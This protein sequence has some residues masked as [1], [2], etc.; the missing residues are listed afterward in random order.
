MILKKFQMIFFK[1]G[2]FSFEN[3]KISLEDIHIDP[4][5]LI[6]MCEIKTS[7]VKRLRIE[8]IEIY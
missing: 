6:H 7:N 4:N 3:V 1:K 8:V 2:S 5:G